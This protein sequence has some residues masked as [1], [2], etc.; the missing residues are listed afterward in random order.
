LEAVGGS[1]WGIKH[2]REKPPHAVA[3][4]RKRSLLE[5]ASPTDLG[6]KRKGSKRAWGNRGKNT[7]EGLGKMTLSKISRGGCSTPKGGGGG[8]SG[9]RRRFAF[10]ER[11]PENRRRDQVYLILIK[12]KELR[13]GSE[14]C[15]GV[16]GRAFGGK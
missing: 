8:K 11:V 7:V 2:Q 13:E 3:I 14:L 6:L 12:G 5:L 1:L 10:E 16:L 15:G 4:S 9:M